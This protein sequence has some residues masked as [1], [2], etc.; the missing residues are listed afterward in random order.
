M[1][2]ADAEV[3]SEWDFYSAAGFKPSTTGGQCN[4]AFQKVGPAQLC[5]MSSIIS[6]QH[7]ISDHYQQFEH[8]S[9]QSCAAWFSLTALCRMIMCQCGQKIVI[10][11]LPIMKVRIC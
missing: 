6:I 1:D 9:A 10:E 8:L 7:V 2:C 3:Y 4:K 11:D 5:N